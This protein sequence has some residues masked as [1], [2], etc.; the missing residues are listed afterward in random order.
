MWRSVGLERMRMRMGSARPS[1]K[2]GGP[3]GADSGELPGPAGLFPRTSFT[4]AP[5]RLQPPWRG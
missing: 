5:P 2:W 1:A 4:V 3:F